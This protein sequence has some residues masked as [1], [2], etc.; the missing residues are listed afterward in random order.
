MPRRKETGQG[1]GRGSGRGRG[2]QRRR[3]GQKGSRGE[4]MRAISSDAAQEDVDMSLNMTTNLHG[5]ENMDVCKSG[6]TFSSF[7][8]F[9]LYP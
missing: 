7:L 4:H 9:R 1:S 6:L 5:D 8:F 2:G 3:G